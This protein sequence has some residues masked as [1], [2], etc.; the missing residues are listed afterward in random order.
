MTTNT[1]SRIRVIGFTSGV[2]FAPQ[3]SLSLS[4]LRCIYVNSST[5]IALLNVQ[6]SL[7]WLPTP[8]KRSE[9]TADQ[10]SWRHAHMLIAFWRGSVGE[11]DLTTVLRPRACRFWLFI[12]TIRSTPGTNHCR[13]RCRGRFENLC[14]NYVDISPMPSPADTC[15]APSTSPQPAATVGTDTLRSPGQQAVK[16][17]S[18]PCLKPFTDPQA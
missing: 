8:L 11:V 17:S 13:A 6:A 15:C 5:T 12:T 3:R 18:A 4:N 16:L 7:A 14:G 2:P 9:C 10:G 1:V